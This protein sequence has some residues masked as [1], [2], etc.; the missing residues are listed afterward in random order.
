M[1]PPATTNSRNA[2]MAGSAWRAASAVICS[3]RLL[4]K[5]SPA[6]TSAPVR[7]CTRLTKAAS[8]SRSLLASNNRP[9]TFGQAQ[10]LQALLHDAHRLAHLLHADAVVVVIVA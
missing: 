5:R 10:L 2:Y 9:P 1:S 4:K 6:T 7:A 8:I 3:I